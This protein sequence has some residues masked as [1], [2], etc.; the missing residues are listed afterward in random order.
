MAQSTSPRALCSFPK[1]R[2]NTCDRRS[3]E[4]NTA[5][6]RIAEL[7]WELACKNV[8]VRMYAE[9]SPVTR[10]RRTRIWVFKGSSNN[11]TPYTMGCKAQFVSRPDFT[12]LRDF[13]AFA[14]FSFEEFA[15][16]VSGF[17]GQVQD[18]REWFMFWDGN[19]LLKKVHILAIVPLMLL[20]Q[21]L[22]GKSFEDLH[23][24][25]TQVAENLRMEFIEQLRSTI[26]ESWQTLNG[27][28]G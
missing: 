12:G 17:P 24:I 3:C 8:I 25:T 15:G 22:R 18:F 23:V 16:I 10:Q 6:Q 14:K 9:T 26:N 13:Q 19:R 2:G 4:M 28:V 11:E 21:A 20:E 27:I 5:D 1:L 7:F